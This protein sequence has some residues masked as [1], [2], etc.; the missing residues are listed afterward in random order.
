MSSLPQLLLKNFVY[1][2]TSSYQWLLPN[3]ESTYKER[4]LYVLA[5]LDG[6]LVSQRMPLIQE[7][8]FAMVE[9]QLQHIDNATHQPYIYPKHQSI[10]SRLFS[11]FKITCTTKLN[12]SHHQSIY[13]IFWSLQVKP[14]KSVKYLYLAV[15][16]KCY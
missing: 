5:S 2:N 14:V 16:R 6:C 7:L 1:K 10:Q 12:K 9:S 3:C 11:A 13:N 4:S 8:T 15:I